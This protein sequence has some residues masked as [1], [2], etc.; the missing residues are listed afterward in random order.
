M[1]IRCLVRRH[2]VIL[3][4]RSRSGPSA[5]PRVSRRRGG[6]A[7]VPG[8]RRPRG[9][10]TGEVL[11]LPLVKTWS[12]TPAQPP[13]PAWP[14]P[15]KEL[16]RIDFDYAFQPVSAGGRVYFGSSADNTVRCLDAGTGRVIWQFTAG[17]P[18]RFAPA[19]AG[20]RC[21]FADDDGWVYCLDAAGGEPAWTLR[22]APRAT[23]S[24]AT[25]G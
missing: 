24:S 5:L 6:L 9:A 1:L 17:G 10:A 20:G 11:S 4:P 15:G 12:Y 14:E 22:A 16:H 25:G 18:V 7:G 8:R 13:R 2:G 19:I 21:T 23:R 3:C